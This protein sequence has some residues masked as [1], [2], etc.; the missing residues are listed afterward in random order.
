MHI[1]DD[2]GSVLYASLCCL[3]HGALLLLAGGVQLGL[4]L[5]NV[6]LRGVSVRSGIR[7]PRFQ[8]LESLARLL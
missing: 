2:S 3:I 8:E 5:L 7:H 4:G 6:G 1:L